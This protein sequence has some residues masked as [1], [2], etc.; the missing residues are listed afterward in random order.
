MHHGSYNVTVECP[1]VASVVQVAPLTG[2]LSDVLVHIKE[3]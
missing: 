1:G 2:K 3:R